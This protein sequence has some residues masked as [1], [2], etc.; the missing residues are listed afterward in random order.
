MMNDKQY[1]LAYQ[2]GH[3]EGMKSEHT[4]ENGSDTFTDDVQIVAFSE[5]LDL[6]ALDEC[7]AVEISDAVYNGA[8][9]AYAERIKLEADF[10][11][12]CSL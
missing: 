11:D 8:Y 1:E 12:Y 9:T 7:S 4:I 2:C 6:E 10:L 5:A 3:R